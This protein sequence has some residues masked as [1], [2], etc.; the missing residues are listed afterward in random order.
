MRHLKVPDAKKPSPLA[1]GE[2][3]ARM[4]LSP[5]GR[6]AAA[7]TKSPLGLWATYVWDAETGAAVLNEFLDA[8]A[9]ALTPADADGKGYRI[10]GRKG[11]GENG[12]QHARHFLA[13]RLRRE[14]TLL[15]TPAAI[16][17]RSRAASTCR[18]G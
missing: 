6:F 8:T 13:D 16:K 17:K 3:S 4:V 5:D 14:P 7:A 15:I 18:T 2:T 11:Q 10:N 9:L 1:K 12:E